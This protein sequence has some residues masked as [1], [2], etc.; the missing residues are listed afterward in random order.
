M[1]AGML[2]VLGVDIRSNER[3][4]SAITPVPGR[5]QPVRVGD[6]PTVLVDYAHTPDGLE[7]ALRGIRDHF[8]GRVWC[9]IGCGGDRDVGKRPQMAACA[10]QFADHVVF[11]SDNPRSESPQSI[12]ADMLAG[13]T[14][15]EAIMV[16]VDRP[17]AVRHAVMQAN[18]EDVVLIAGKGHERWQEVAGERLP[19]DDVVLARQAL[20]ERGERTS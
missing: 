19:M 4:L 2:A 1:V 11:T 14:A 9:V 7:K 10:E 18:A 12:V 3:A 13:V 8:S 6:G 5:M 17:A 16:L 20:I 15:A